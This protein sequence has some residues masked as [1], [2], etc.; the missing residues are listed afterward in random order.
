MMHKFCKRILIVLTVVILLFTTNLGAFKTSEAHA[1][2][3]AAQ[4]AG[5]SIAS[6]FASV[7]TTVSAVGASAAHAEDFIT[8]Q[9][10]AIYDV[11]KAAWPK[12]SAEMQANFRQSMSKMADGIIVAGDWITVGLD[13]LKSDLGS[14]VPS[15]GGT[16]DTTF[17]LYYLPSGYSILINGKS[18]T[19]F[20]VQGLNDTGSI[21]NL[22]IQYYIS[23][24]LNEYLTKRFD[25]VT[26]HNVGIV[27]ADSMIKS[28]N[29]ISDVM[30]V[31][32]Y[33]GA[34]ATLQYNGL[35]VQ[36]NTYNRI[37]E[38]LRDIAIPAGNLGVYAPSEAWTQSGYRLGLSEDGQ[39][40]L[41]LPDGLPYDP[42]IDGPYTWRAPLTKGIN[43]VAG[44]LDTA[45]GS[46]I[47]ITTGKKIR[48][49]TVTEM[50][51]GTGVDESTAEIVLIKAKEE[52]K[53]REEEVDTDIGE[54]AGKPYEGDRNPDVDFRN[55]KG[56]STLDRH[57]DDHGNVSSEKYLQNARNF[58]DKP[59]T[60]TTQTFVSKEGTYFRYDTATNEFGIINKYGGISTYF[61]PDDKILYWRLQIEKYAPK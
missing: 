18:V 17:K 32:S 6:Y 49:A 54:Y 11:A 10:Q 29:S 27:T 24:N 40:L 39:T 36:L 33:F 53:A 28:I 55:G 16:V 8:D 44:V 30:D 52:E 9:G 31:L 20:G 2:S 22:V 59:P 19:S 48:D 5:E 4:F 46:W 3:W 15:T 42:V 14:S 34:T 43:G 37:D 41:K 35:P 7:M 45:I 47:D 26:D 60:T 58:L 23:G 38:W 51:T 61:K 25:N 57:A 1:N 21:Y 12:M 50:A 56:K 13:A